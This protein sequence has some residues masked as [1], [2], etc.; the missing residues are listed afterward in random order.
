[1]SQGFTSDLGVTGPIG[2]TGPMGPQGPTGP[3]G[4]QTPWASDIQASGYRLTGTKVVYFAGEVNNGSSGS[5]TVN[6][7]WTA[8]QKQTLTLNGS[9]TLT[10][11][12]PEGPGNVILRLVHD[13]T[14]T[15]YII[16]WPTMKWVGATP[17]T[18]TATA[19]AVDIIT[20]YFDGSNYWGSYGLN[21]G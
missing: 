11:T 15:A 2:P 13:G 4:P 20:I 21:F 7:D 12:A 1:M 6:I 9:P 17:P 16:T 5:G 19:S 18:L 14:T 8:G 10:F 3:Q